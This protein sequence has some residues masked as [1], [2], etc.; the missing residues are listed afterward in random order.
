MTGFTGKFHRAATAPPPRKT[1]DQSAPVSSN[2]H[3]NGSKIRYK[4]LNTGRRMMLEQMRLVGILAVTGCLLLAVETTLPGRIDLPGMGA[5]APSLGLLFCMAVG[6]LWR[7]EEGAVAGLCMGWLA[8]ATGG[9]GMMLL[10]LLYFLCGYLSGLGG[11]RRLA[12]NLP[13]FVVFAVL[14]GGAEVVFTVV[15]EMI[16]SRG[17]PPLI[18]TLRGAI[19]VWILT[20]AASPVVYGILFA[21]RYALH[22]HDSKTY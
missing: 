10:P 19:P 11:R 6:F 12:H 3:P 2:I 1:G 18:W 17:V 20:V 13:S 9:Q 15:R 5:A 21:V 7:E 14:G 8:D 16:L 22:H 4:R